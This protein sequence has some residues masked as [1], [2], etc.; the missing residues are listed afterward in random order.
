M[1][2]SLTFDGSPARVLIGNDQEWSARSL[3]SVIVPLGC[4]VIR[5]FTGRQVLDA[6]QNNVCDLVLLD[7]QLPDIHGF[8]VCRQLRSPAFLGAG[9][10]IIMTTSGPAGR[11][12]RLEALRAGAW[13]FLAEPMDVDLLLPRL[14]TFIEAR[15]ALLFPPNRGPVPA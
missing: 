5:A 7:T 13:E 11:A 12:Q 6:A 9:T 8:D 10:P 3:E 1:L 15:R 14:S 2:V 4:E